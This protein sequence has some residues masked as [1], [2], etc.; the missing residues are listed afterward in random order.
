[1][2]EEEVGEEEDYQAE[3]DS[4]PISESELE[5][6]RGDSHSPSYSVTSH[7]DVDKLP[8]IGA[9]GHSD[10][11]GQGEA[12]G[13]YRASPSPLLPLHFTK[14]PRGKPRRTKSPPFDSTV[15]LGINGRDDNRV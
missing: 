11:H 2:G 13:I 5:V 8:S 6:A 14:S 12:E 10:G 1:M 4:G 9:D 15:P 7:F 3:R